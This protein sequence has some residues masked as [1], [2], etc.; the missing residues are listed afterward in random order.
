MPLNFTKSQTTRHYIRV[1]HELLRKWS[2]V[3]N[4]KVQC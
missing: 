4:Q 3:Q 2:C 1:Q